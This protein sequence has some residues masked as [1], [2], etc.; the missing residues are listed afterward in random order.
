M[1][2]VLFIPLQLYL[3][4]A[5]IRQQEHNGTWSWPMFAFAMGFVLFECLIL[6]LPLR[7]GMAESPYFVPV[8]VAAWIIAAFNFIWFL[9]VCRRWKPKPPSN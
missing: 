8:W 4:F 7:L 2:W 9:R 6:I 3:I 5:G 1:I